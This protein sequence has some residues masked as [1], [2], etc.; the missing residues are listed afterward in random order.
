MASTRWQGWRSC[1][2]FT[3]TYL[4][5]ERI[6]ER[7]GFRLAALVPRAPRRELQQFWHRLD[8]PVGVIGLHMAEIGAKPEHLPIRVEPLAVPAHDGADGERVTQIVDARSPSM[9]AEAR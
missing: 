7:R 2:A 5:N 4:K 6:A 9:L 1:V 8:V 3:A